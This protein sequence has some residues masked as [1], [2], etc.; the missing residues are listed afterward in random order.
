MSRV[1]S[2]EQP[3]R[4]GQRASDINRG[5]YSPPKRISFRQRQ[6]CVR[7]IQP[8]AAPRPGRPVVGS[9]RNRR[10]DRIT[11]GHRRARQGKCRR[12]LVPGAARSS[13]TTPLYAGLTGVSRQCGTPRKGGYMP[14][15]AKQA[16]VAE[17]VELFRETD[18]S[19]VSDHRGLTV[20]DLSKV[21]GEL[22]EQG[23]QLSDHQEP[24]GQDRSRA[25]GATR[26]G[27]VAVGPECPGLRRR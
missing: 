13:V 5:G 15:Q 19:I 11:R 26:V 18:T 4:I 22:R 7:G 3:R 9:D 6:R 17:L 10:S 1:F 12:N 23:H 27:A 2:R 25:G 20:A 24:A 16:A 8:G 14:T 21:R